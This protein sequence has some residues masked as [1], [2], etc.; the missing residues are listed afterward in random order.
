MSTRTRTRGFTLVELLVVIAI[1]ALLIGILLPALGAARR[2]AQASASASN[3][4]GFAS[5]FKIHAAEDRQARLTTGMFDWI[6]DGDVRKVGWVF[7]LIRLKVS[8]PGQSLDPANPHVIN[9]KVLDYYGIK[10]FDDTAGKGSLWDPTNTDTVDVPFMTEATYPAGSATASATTDANENSKKAWEDGYNTNYATSWYFGRGDQISTALTA[11]NFYSDTSWYD[12]K[13]PLNGTGPISENNLAIAIVSSDRIP[14]MAESRSGNGS[15][16][17]INSSEAAIFNAMISGTDSPPSALNVFATA[18]DVAVESFCDG[19]NALDTSTVTGDGT[20]TGSSSAVTLGG[21]GD[22]HELNDFW[23]VHGS[24][25]QQIAVAS[26]GGGPIQQLT[27]GFCNI[28]F[29]DG[30]V[31]KVYDT[32]GIGVLSDGWIGPFPSSWDGS[33]YGAFACDDE[34]RKELDG[35]V[36]IEA[37]FLPTQNSAGKD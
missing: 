24:S 25:R 12:D 13:E 23:P 6:R 14:L 31:G 34:C 30:H 2:T 22:V 37:K 15:D 5:G 28:M 8:N 9:E 17:E 21:G 10:N 1:I 26:G 16:A 4:R 18:G 7:D 33:N 19:I 20:N 3:L 11:A 35:K 27:G 36:W 29:A 32:T